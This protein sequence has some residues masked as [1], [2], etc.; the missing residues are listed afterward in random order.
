MGPDIRLM[1]T[2]AIMTATM[3]TPAQ[4]DENCDYQCTSRGGCTVDYVGPPR[5]GNSQGSCFPEDFGGSCSTTPT[6][7]QDCNKAISC[8]SG[9]EQTRPTARP[10]IR[11][12]A[13]PT[14]RPTIRAPST[15]DENCD[16]QCTS[17]GGCTV[18]YVG[19]L[20]EGN[21]QGS[22]FPE[23]F[24][25]SCKGT[26]TECQDCNKAITCGSGSGQTRPTARPTA[27]PAIRPATRPTAR[28]PS[29]GDQNC[30]YQCTSRGGC[31]VRYVGPPREGND[32]GSCFPEDFGGSCK[33]TP[34]ECQDC[35]KAITCG[36]EN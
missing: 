30:D 16:Y 34:T 8:G 18:D 14:T 28:P 10:T 11:P 4:G 20:R 21:N 19:P 7:C 22:C 9:S 24:G 29:T 32:Q 13:Q 12:I 36:S 15:G 35:N 3:T 27:R 2:L 5:E 33:G 17:R 23:D 31:Q 25:G 26:P 1:A 6:E